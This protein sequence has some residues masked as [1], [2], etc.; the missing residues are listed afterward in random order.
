VIRS[1][2]PD[3][4]IDVDTGAPDGCGGTDTPGARAEADRSGDESVTPPS[5][6]LTKTRH[7]LSQV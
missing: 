6:S 4:G 7:S 3:P 2:P 5:S 1:V